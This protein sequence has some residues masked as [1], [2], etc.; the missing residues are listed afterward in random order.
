MNVKLFKPKVFS[1]RLFSFFIALFMLSCNKDEGED[2]AVNID[3]NGFWVASETTTG[4]CSG[5]MSTE[6]K[7][8]IYSIAQ[9]GNDFTITFYPAENKVD[10]KLIGNKISWNGTIPTSSG[11]TAMNFAGEVDNTGTTVTGNGNWTW[12]SETFQCSGSVKVNAQKV[13]AQ[14]ADFSGN[15]QGTWQSEESSYSGTFSVNAVQN[16]NLLSGSINVPEIGLS[17]ADLTGQVS[18]NIVFFGDIAGT[19]KFVGRLNNNTG[20]GDFAYPDFQEEGSWTGTRQ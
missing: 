18:G 15:W 4:N 13:V 5:S 16:D 20:A 8:M 19:I 14:T 10:G 9:N 1:L 17:N 12:S 7:T 6:T 11:N 3:A 2:T